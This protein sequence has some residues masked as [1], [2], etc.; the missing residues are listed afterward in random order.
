MG[1]DKLSTRSSLSFPE[2][3]RSR[4]EDI[5]ATAALQ[6]RFRDHPDTRIR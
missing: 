1:I 4:R 3:Q 6:D 5:M 2:F